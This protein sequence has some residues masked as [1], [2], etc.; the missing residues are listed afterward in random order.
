MRSQLTDGRLAIRAYWPGVAAAKFEAVNESMAEIGPSFS[1]WYEGIPLAEVAKHVQ[2][3]VQA[4]QEGTWY[5]FAVTPA[6]S[7]AY[8]GHAGLDHVD[9]GTGTTNV[10]YWVRSSQTG[11]GVATA[12]VRLLTQFAFEDLGLQRLELVITIGNQPSRRVAEKLEARCEGTLPA[13]MHRGQVHLDHV[14]WCYVLA[15]T[16]QR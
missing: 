14:S 10:G 1:N 4:W 16:A 15:R 7:D 13:G 6:D 8:L 2:E 5:D 9:Q 3:S 11:R 12:A